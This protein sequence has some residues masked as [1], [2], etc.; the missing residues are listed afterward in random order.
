LRRSQPKK[1]DILRFS[2]VSLNMLSRE[3]K[4]GND[5]I[6][7][8]TQEYALLELFLRHPNQVLTRNRI[9]EIVWGYDFEGESNVMEVYVSYLRTKLEAG[10]RPKLIHTVRGVGYVLKE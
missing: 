5:V 2:D 10:N 4:R 6:E 1:G 7:L 8:T 3:A 9:Y